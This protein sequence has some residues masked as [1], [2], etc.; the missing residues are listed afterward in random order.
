MNKIEKYLKTEFEV[1]MMACMHGFVMIFAY[2]LEKFVMGFDNISFLQALGMGSLA[3]LISWIQKIIFLKEKVYGKREF[4]VRAVCW[5]TIPCILTY[6]SGV[7]LGWFREL[8][9]GFAIIF[10]AFVSFYYILLW[11]FLQRLFR[12]DSQKLN[13]LL[14]NYK[15][16]AEE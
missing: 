16:Q 13:Y 9:W 3:Y 1:E 5:S 14:R 8:H 15:D 12:E 10:Y 7:L 6:I 4:K 11:F 2:L